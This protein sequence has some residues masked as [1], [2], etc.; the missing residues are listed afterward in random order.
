MKKTAFLL[1]IAATLIGGE[2]S[3]ASLPVPTAS[4][5]QTDHKPHRPRKKRGFL[6]G[7]FRRNS[8]NCPKH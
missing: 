2:V 5:Q 6:W 3:A 8:C 4:S 1:L 7:L